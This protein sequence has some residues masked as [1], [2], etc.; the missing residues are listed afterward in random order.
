MAG[1][2]RGLL[3]LRRLCW[4]GHFKLP[5]NLMT[6][7]ELLS[8]I[9]EAHSAYNLMLRLRRAGVDAA[10]ADLTGWRGS[11]SVT[12]DRRITEAL[13]PLDLSRHLPIVTSYA[14]CAESLLQLYGRGYSQQPSP[15]P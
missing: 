8:G 15:P 2:G 13:A 1:A 11:E 6:V 3:D 4:F 9:G 5:E 14:Q 7:R 10:F 12:L